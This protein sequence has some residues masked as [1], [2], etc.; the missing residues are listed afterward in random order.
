M[1]LKRSVILFLG[2]FCIIF[3]G[4]LHYMDSS[5]K[6]LSLLKGMSVYPIVRLSY[7]I[8][9]CAGWYTQRTTTI[10]ELVN[11][12]EKLQKECCFFREKYIQLQSYQ[13]YTQ[14]IASLFEKI[15]TI[16]SLDVIRIGLVLTRHFSSKEHYF[17]VDKGSYDGIVQDM[18][19]CVDSCL[20]GRVAEVFPTYCKILLI[21]DSK[22]SIPVLCG[23]KKIAGIL[24]GSNR[25]EATIKYADQLQPILEN[26]LIITS[27][28][29][30]IFPY[31]I[32]VGTVCSVYNEEKNKIITVKPFVDYKDIRYCY[33]IQKDEIHFN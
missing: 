3:F 1:H 20:V 27:G 23:E 17:F 33:L 5:F 4:I 2:F 12:C 28:I 29:G 13:W 22:C 15:D 31:G 18:V 19:A 8:S 14:D 30:F 11:R 24:Q 10:N 6:P 7:I 25:L 9:D 21:T 32:G 16:Y 26:D